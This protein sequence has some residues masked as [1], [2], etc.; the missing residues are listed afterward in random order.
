MPPHGCHMCVSRTSCAR[1]CAADAQS[2]EGA[3]EAVRSVADR[4]SHCGSHLLELIS[5]P[6][7]EPSSIRLLRRFAVWLRRLVRRLQGLVRRLVQRPRATREELLE[8]AAR[9]VPPSARLRPAAHA[10]SEH[11]VARSASAG[12]AGAAQGAR[13]QARRKKFGDWGDAC[14]ERLGSP[15]SPTLEKPV[16]PRGLSDGA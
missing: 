6:P 9:R 10:A 3:H 15:S 16:P 13:R 11:C 14:S 2:D 7:E 8:A 1:R 4:V 12:P 5:I